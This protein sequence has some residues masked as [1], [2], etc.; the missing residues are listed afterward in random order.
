MT[1]NDP[2]IRIEFRPFCWSQIIVIN[3]TDTK[4]WC[5]M[6]GPL[7]IDVGVYE[8]AEVSGWFQYHRKG[9]VFTSDRGWLLNE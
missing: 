9:N 6:V 7:V 2:Y 1:K 3:N 8:K 5:L 4:Q